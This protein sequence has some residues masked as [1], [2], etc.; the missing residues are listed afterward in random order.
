MIPK[1]VK[2]A[3]NPISHVSI[4]FLNTLS[5]V[6][7]YLLVDQL[8]L[9]RTPRPEKFGFR[10]QHRTTTQLVNIIDHITNNFKIRHKTAVAFLS[11]EIAF[12]K[13]WHD[14][15]IYKMIQTG[16]PSQ[17]TNIIQFFL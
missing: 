15:L 10:A 7:K 3:K 6:Y 5:E 1:P 2:N 9:S 17:L 12:N 11:I 13:V 4:S 14:G 8:K 16:I